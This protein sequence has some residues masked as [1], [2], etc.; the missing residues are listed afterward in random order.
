MRPEEKA[1][2][3][4]YLE[5][6]TDVAWFANSANVQGI[7]GRVRNLVLEWG[8]RLE[9]LGIKGEGLSFSP[10]EKTKAAASAITIGKIENFAGNLGTSINQSSIQATQTKVGVIDL[11]AIQALVAQINKH[12]DE[13]PAR[14]VSA[15]RNEIENLNKE[16]QSAAPN[17]TKVMA[18][19]GSIKS[20]LEGAAGNL[21]AS[22]I[23]AELAKILPH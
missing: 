15:V 10:A 6:P 8:L 4:G 17:R 18:A 13:L 5:F 2:L 22:G 9:K 16:F 19:L 21:I 23:L 20:A 7:P 12:T 11:D 3:V 1:R 14:S